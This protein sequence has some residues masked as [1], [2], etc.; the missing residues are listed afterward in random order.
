MSSGSPLALRAFRSEITDQAPV[1]NH[2]KG[3]IMLAKVK[4]FPTT[5]TSTTQAI[6]VT[7]DPTT[8]LPAS[9]FTITPNLIVV[10]PRTTT[11]LEVTLTTV[12]SP[13]GPATWANVPVSWTN[14]PASGAPLVM[15][16]SN[17]P[18]T[19]YFQVPAPTRYFVPWVFNF[20]I[21]FAGVNN[22]TSPACFLVKDLDDSP[23]F[24]LQYTP[25][26]GSFVLSRNN[27]EADLVL[28]SQGLLLNTRPV[29]VHIVIAGATFAQN[30]IVWKNNGTLGSPGNPGPLGTPQWLTVST[31]PPDQPPS[32]LTL[33]LS[34][35][36]NNQS[37]GFQFAVNVNGV[38]VLSPDPIII[39]ATIGDGGVT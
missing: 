15:T 26:D 11:T 12:N 5:E 20:N 10:D 37:A 23:P 30:P 38:T 7:Y 36:I 33:S 18:S 16:E 6:T 39:N 14:P 17:D 19:I 29:E 1:I 28:A 3:D 21:N 2:W 8:P 13:Q 24:T 22:I 31:S 27:V 32:L 9:P 35:P 4:Q 25:S 34:E